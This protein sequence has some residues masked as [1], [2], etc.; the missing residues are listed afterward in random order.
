MSWMSP[1]EMTELFRGQEDSLT[2]TFDSALRIAQVCGLTILRFLDVAQKDLIN[3][4]VL[5]LFPDM[6]SVYAGL[7]QKWKK[8]SEQEELKKEFENLVKQ[9]GFKM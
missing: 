3:T 7:N 1:T 8:V 2:F 5:D 9:T 4:T 6:Q